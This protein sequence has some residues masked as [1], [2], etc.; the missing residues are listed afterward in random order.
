MDASVAEPATAGAGEGP[1]LELDGFA[2]PLASLLSL[3][4]EHAIVWRVSHWRTASGS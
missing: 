1:H 3:A 2:G 4:R